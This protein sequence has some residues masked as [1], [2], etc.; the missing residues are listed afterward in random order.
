MA[1]ELLGGILA[2]GPRWADP[3]K[4]WGDVLRQQ[5]SLKEAIEKYT[6]ALKFAPNWAGLKKAANPSQQKS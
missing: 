3:L 5:G 4:A 2:R 1:D 6:E